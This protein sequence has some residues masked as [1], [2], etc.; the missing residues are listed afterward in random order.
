MVSKNT[1]YLQSVE[2]VLRDLNVPFDIKPGRKHLKLHMLINGITYVRGISSSSSDVRA[3]YNIRSQLRRFVR[4]RR[5][6]RA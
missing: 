6:A 1:E 4:E 2:N 5:E 3:V